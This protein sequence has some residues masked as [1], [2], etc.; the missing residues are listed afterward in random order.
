MG[1]IMPVLH[2]VMRTRFFIPLMALLFFICLFPSS[3]Y[4]DPFMGPW[5]DNSSDETS[6]KRVS[7]D[8]NPLSSLVKAYRNYISPIDGK[9]CPMYP[10]CSKYSILCFEKHGFLMG[11]V[12]TCD[13]LIHE[14]DEMWMAPAIYVDGVE[15]YYD[16]IENN[17]FWWHSEG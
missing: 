13:R 1:F 3:V 7:S 11:W 10:S 15:R 12:M 8:F 14:A 5:E 16:P 2:N 17:D 6:C 9:T 4:G